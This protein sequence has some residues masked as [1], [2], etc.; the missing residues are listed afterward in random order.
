MK[1]RR[2]TSMVRLAILAIVALVGSL[3]ATAGFAA[4]TDEPVAEVLSQTT[5]CVDDALDPYGFEDVD[6]LSSEW[7]DAI[8]C[9]A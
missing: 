5:A 2:S 3:M 1:K 6:G 7:Q 4:A 9:I 8:N